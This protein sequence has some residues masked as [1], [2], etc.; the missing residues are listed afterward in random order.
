MGISRHNPSRYDAFQH[1]P[2]CKEETPHKLGLIASGKA[3]LVCGTVRMEVY[4]GTFRKCENCG[5]FVRVKSHI[6]DGLRGTDDPELIPRMA[7]PHVCSMAKAA[8]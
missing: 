4:Q 1:C 8:H 7:E 2:V 3:C 6:D 5:E